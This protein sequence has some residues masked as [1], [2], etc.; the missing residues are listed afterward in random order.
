MGKESQGTQETCRYPTAFRN[1]RPIQD[2]QDYSEPG[3]EPLGGY[4]GSEGG[5]RPAQGCARGRWVKFA[6]LQVA[7]E[8]RACGECSGRPSTWWFGLKGLGWRGR[9][10]PYGAIPRSSWASEKLTDQ[11]NLAQRPGGFV[12][13]YGT[14][15][16][17]IWFYPREAQRTHRTMPIST[18]HP[19]TLLSE[20]RS[21]SGCWG[22][23]WI[24]LYWPSPHLLPTCALWVL[25]PPLP[26]P[27]PSPWS[28][29]CLECP[30][31]DGHL[32]QEAFLD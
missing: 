18:H 17:A 8:P 21:L 5:P 23:S 2:Q 1:K 15:V 19:S 26:I 24:S 20:T 22:G 4:A 3:C 30:R 16:F 29:L 31:T 25:R 13:T 32:F 7:A 9:L 28:H 14:W 12:K 11:A 27:K 10:S 6:S